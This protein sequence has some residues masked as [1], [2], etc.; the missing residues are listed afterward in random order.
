MARRLFERTL[1]L[2]GEMTPRLQDRRPGVQESGAQVHSRLPA[3]RHRPP[4]GLLA[5][6]SYRTFHP[7]T[8]PP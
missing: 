6:V 3:Q 1:N 5:P 8:G 7:L 4:P 2:G